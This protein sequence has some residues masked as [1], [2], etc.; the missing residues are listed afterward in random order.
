MTTC[1]SLQFISS[2]KNLTCFRCF[3]F[4]KAL[5]KTQTRNKIKCL[6]SNNGGE[7]TSSHFIKFLKTMAY[8]N[9]ILFLIYL[10]KMGCQNK[11]ITLWLN[12]LEAC[13][14]HLNCHI[15]FG[16]R[17]CYNLLH[18][19]LL[20]NILD[21]FLTKHHSNYGQ[22]CNLICVIFLFLVALHMNMCQIRNDK[23]L[24]QKHTNAFW[25]GMGNDMV[26]KVTI[27]MIKPQIDSL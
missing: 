2:R 25:L 11:R 9:N 27:C 14:Q 8:L 6:K 4:Y 23:S 16:L 19:K 13:L 21:W 15:N 18:S 26:L 1:G 20:L 17:L 5:V 22:A 24:I 3:L 10:N 12:L 7:Y